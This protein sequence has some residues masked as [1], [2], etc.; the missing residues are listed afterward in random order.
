MQKPVSDANPASA[1]HD[2]KE[3]GR[4]AARVGDEIITMHELKVATKEQYNR[5]KPQQPRSEFAIEDQTEKH[6]EILILAKQTLDG[7]IDRSLLVQEA[8]RAIKNPKQ[9]DKFMEMADKVWRDEQLPPLEY[10]YHVD[11]EQQLRDKLAEEGRSLDAMSQA[12][13]QDYLAFGFLHEK[14][15]DRVK[16]ELPD[17]LK[18]YN[19]HIHDREFDRPAQITWRE[20]VV[21]VDKYPNRDQARR[22]AD[23]LLEKLR[24]GADFA[25]LARTESDGPTST[26]NQGGMMQTSPGGY[27]VTA[28]NAALQSLPIGQVSGVLEG[29]SS[30][31]I[32][33]VEKRRPAGPASFEELQDTI[34]SLLSDQR[35]QAER[36]AFLA[37]LRQRTLVS[38]IFDGI[39]FDP[40]RATP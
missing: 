4:S 34:R 19:E 28:V 12:F 3:A 38:N 1:R 39:E 9:V 2:W 13:R 21:E 6:K 16:V 26:R 7:L 15:R 14:L 18:Y 20:L 22:K 11:T 24:R 33:R 23:A 37:K 17:L 8:K 31:H 29:S 35:F 30:Y 40:T 25:Q 32:V 10:R 36:T 27:A 5:F